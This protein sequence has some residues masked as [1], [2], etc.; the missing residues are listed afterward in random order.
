MFLFLSLISG[1]ILGIGLGIAEMT[2]PSVVLNFLDIAGVWDIRLMFVMAGAIGV[3]FLF[4]QLV[5]KKREIPVYGPKFCMPVKVKLDPR[6]IIGSLIFGVG[7][8]LCGVCPGVAYIQLGLFDINIVY[9]ICA[10]LLGN[11]TFR[12]LNHYILSK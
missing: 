11:F 12:V 1:L 7:W 9:F 2:K 4:Y 5:I 10:M 6:L 3:H 8:G